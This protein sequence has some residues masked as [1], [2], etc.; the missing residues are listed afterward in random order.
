MSGPE[1]LHIDRQ[2]LR[3]LGLFLAALAGL[4][5]VF[6]GLPSVFQQLYMLPIS[7]LS[8]ALL[9]VLS[10]DTILDTT[11]LSDGFCELAVRRVIYRITFDCTGIFAVLAYTALTVAYPATHRLRILGLALGLPA[12]FTFSV[13]RITVLGIVARLEPAWIEVFHVYVMELAT[14]GFMLFAWTY[15]LGQVRRA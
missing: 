2:S 5:I 11:H 1:F 7:H 3:F 9:H 14:L 10:I 15:W 12:I 8:A 6:E 13:L 4:G